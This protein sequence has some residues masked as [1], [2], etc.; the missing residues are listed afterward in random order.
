MIY[1]QTGS[2]NSVL[3]IKDLEFGLKSALDRLGNKKKVLVVPPDFTRFHSRAGDITTLI[4]KYYGKN[5]KDI[6]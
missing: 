6:L 5:L 4:Y 1:Y 3:S 2:E